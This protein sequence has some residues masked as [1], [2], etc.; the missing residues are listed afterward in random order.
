MK[1]SLS[2]AP[3]PSQVFKDLQS[4]NP[5][6]LSLQVPPQVRVLHFLSSNLYKELPCLLCGKQARLPY[7]SELC[8]FL[9]TRIVH[10]QKN[11]LAPPWWKAWRKKRVTQWALTAPGLLHLTGKLKSILDKNTLLPALRSK[12]T[13]VTKQMIKLILPLLGTQFEPRYIDLRNYQLDLISSLGA[14][15]RRA[16]CICTGVNTMH[17]VMFQERWIA[18]IKE[19]S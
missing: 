13:V 19:N 9:V 2:S 18:R 5:I 3:H 16:G 1:P 12:I 15:S 14:G 6:T 11:Y 17:R 8:F 10:P 4:G 7:F